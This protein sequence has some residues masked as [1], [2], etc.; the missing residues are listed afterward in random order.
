MTTPAHVA[1]DLRSDAIAVALTGAWLLIVR[2]A[3]DCP[4]GFAPQPTP[5]GVSVGIVFNP[6]DTWFYLSWVQQ[7]FAGEW[8]AGLLYTTEAHPALLWLFPLWAIGRVAA[9]TG[10][11][12]IGVFNVTGLIGALASVFFFRR[13]ARAIGLS[14]SA[15]DWATVVLLLGSG[16]SWFAHAFHR[17]GWLGGFR[18]AE[19]VYL[20]LFP[21]TLIHVYAYHA[22]GLAVLTALWWCVAE[23]ENRL[24]E[25]Q[26]AG[27]WICAVA[28][29]GLLL[30]FSRPYEPA[31][32]MA[33]Y[34]LKTGWCWLNR[35]SDGEAWRA[36][37]ISV[38]LVAAALAPG[39]VWTAY[40]SMQPIWETF[41]QQA[42][43][44]G[45]SRA[46]WLAAFGGLWALAAIGMPPAVRLPASRGI[47]AVIAVGLS[48]VVLVG[49][50]SAQVKLA[51]GLFVGTALVGGIGADEIVR[52]LR[53][54]LPDAWVVLA[55]ASVLMVAL[56]I[57][58]LFMNLRAIRLT[59]PALLHPEL[60]SLAQTI[61][62]L[63]DNR[64]SVVLADSRVGNVLPGLIGVRVWVGHWGVTHHFAEKELEA[65][66]A[67][68]DPEF[69]PGDPA[70]IDQPLLRIVSKT[71]FDYGLLERS[72]AGA[73]EILNRYG[74]E[75]CRSTEHWVLLR[76]PST[77]D[78]SR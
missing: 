68:L 22:A 71:R 8:R 34:A 77:P 17:L 30:G 69:L 18:G 54:R 55:G 3:L 40:I 23:L 39:L 41:A 29:A 20:D 36:C 70:S 43:A 46:V 42:L 60:F 32:F 73:L 1:V 57:G 12:P 52:W 35:R 49:L 11:S 14:P 33:A 13:T 61:P 5:G 6:T 50:A 51:S 59:G 4:W 64:P 24:R 10:L 21:S 25:R 48:I 16:G 76:A 65:R 26:R 62:R 63:T 58:S 56:G 53:Q 44:L 72:C 74:W 7:Y 15:R 45:Q 2:V 27:R 66:R 37:R 31:A 19:F 67:G 9:W 38:G 78:Y 28:V 47:L 75:P